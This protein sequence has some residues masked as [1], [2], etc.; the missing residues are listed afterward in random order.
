MPIDSSGPRAADPARPGE[1]SRSASSR[2]ATNV[3]RASSARST[4]RP[5]VIR[6]RR[7]RRSSAAR[8][9]TAPTSSSGSKPAFAASASTLTCRS[10]GTRSPG[11]T[12]SARR[13]RRSASSIE[14]TDSITAKVARARFAL[15]DW[16]GP[17]RCQVAPSTSAAFASPSCTRFSPKTV[18]PASTA[19][20]TR[21]AGTVFE[22]ATSVTSAGSRPDREHASAIIPRTRARAAESSATSVTREPP[23]RNLLL[24]PQER[25]DLEVVGIVGGRPLDRHRLADGA[26]DARGHDG[27][28]GTLLAAVLAAVVVRLEP[29]ALELLE[30]ITLA[31]RAHGVLVDRRLGGLGVPGGVALAGAVEAGGDD[32]DHHL[33]AEPVVE[34]RPEDDVRLRIGGGTDL[35]GGLGHLEEA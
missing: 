20:T 4:C 29:L 23:G 26:L 7:S 15:L 30:E 19:A 6:P 16:R 13:S 2:R 12:S 27:S 28:R 32:R 8:R 1:R 5:T 25:R 18:S 14:S 17:T 31:R 21:S 34:A 33:F 3:E 22:T 9:G 10:T 35:F 24:A 11:R